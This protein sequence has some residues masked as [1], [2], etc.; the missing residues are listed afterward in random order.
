M[1]ISET[2]LKMNLS[3]SHSLCEAEPGKTGAEPSGFQE[4]EL[5]MTTGTNSGSPR[6]PGSIFVVTGHI[7]GLSASA[8][9]VVSLQV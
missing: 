2:G 9:Y 5:C 1:F 3:C 4:A 8:H 7:Q 6:T